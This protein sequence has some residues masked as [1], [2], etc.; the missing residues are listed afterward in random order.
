MRDV[1][2]VSSRSGFDHLGYTLSGRFLYLGPMKSTY[3]KIPIVF[4][5]IFLLSDLSAQPMQM[6]KLDGLDSMNLSVTNKVF[7]LLE[8]KKVNDAL[9]YFE[10]KDASHKNSISAHLGKI[11]NDLQLIK[12]TA[13]F[14]A[15]RSYK[16]YSDSFNIDRI[17][18]YDNYG[19]FYLFELFYLKN[20]SFSKVVDIFIK[21]PIGLAK[22]RQKEI[23][24]RKKNTDA[25]P[26]PPLTLPPGLWFKERN[27]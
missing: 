16:N 14:A 11:S 17:A 20:D 23:D 15:Q 24:F 3:L 19:Y 1:S 12:S 9:K 2:P 18:Y 5:F 4:V 8:Q 27:N 7:A 13:K 26:P 10:F 21:D 22:S 25:P 6:P